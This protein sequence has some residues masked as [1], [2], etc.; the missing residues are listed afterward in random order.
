MSRKAFIRTTAIAVSAAVVAGLGLIAVAPAQATVTGGATLSPATGG[1]NSL[2]SI[3]SSGPCV[4]PA[5]RVKVTV[6]GFGL[7]IN[8]V[9]P[10]AIGFS[11]TGPMTLPFSNSFLVYANNNST[12][13]DGDYDVRIQCINNLGTVVYDEFRNK[14]TWTTPGNSIANIANATYVS[15]ADA[16]AVATTTTVTAT[17]S[18]QDEG[19]NVTLDAVVDAGATDPNAGTVEFFRG[20][21][22]LGT[23]PVSAGAA[24]LVVNNLPVGSNSITAVFSG[25][26]GF[27]GS[28]SS[29]I[30]VTINDV[31]VS[32]TTTLAVSGSLQQFSP[33]TLDATVVPNNAV[34][35]VVFKD[36]ATVLATRPLASGTAQFVTSNLALG[37]HSLTAEFVPANA[38]D[39][40]ASSSAP[41]NITIV[42]PANPTDAQDVIVE[43]PAGALTISVGGDKSVTL[44]PVITADGARFIDSSTMDDVTV[45]DTRA[46]SV[47][48]TVNGQLGAFNYTGS[49]PGATVSNTDIG[50]TPAVRSTSGS[51]VVTASAIVTPDFEG[52]PAGLSVSSPLA[53]SPVGSSTGTAVIG[54]DLKINSDTDIAPGTHVAVLT[55]TAI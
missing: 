14:M 41:Q 11:T 53:T 24:Q 49:A 47:G 35:D 1:V 5:T 27:S 7:N 18:T 25:T 2:I 37:A 26:S 39:F 30:S 52:S 19:Q 50:W 28:T 55:F 6:V 42:V 17:P 4:A 23:A 13:L 9:A 36:G 12:Y 3:T 8:A 10:T 16:P 38:N 44:N 22:S 34:G 21:T 32:T 43:V 48:W 51:Q 40:A 33:V 46:G 31:I 15:Q 29:A 45:L 20:A 54:G